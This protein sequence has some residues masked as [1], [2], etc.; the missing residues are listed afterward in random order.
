[1]MALSFSI[2]SC[3]S[4]ELKI[5]TVLLPSPSRQIVG[6]ASFRRIKFFSANP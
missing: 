1:M 2:D 5:V 3:C 6:L 4:R